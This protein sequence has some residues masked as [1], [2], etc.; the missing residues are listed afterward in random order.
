LAKNLELKVKISSFDDIKA[1][2]GKIRIAHETTLNQKDIYYKWN[3]GLLKLRAE[4][5][6]CHLIKY[7]R[8]ERK[9]KRF[10]N[11]Q[12]IQL[13][14]EDPENY[15]SEILSIEA[16][17]EKKRKLFIYKNTRIHLDEVKNLGKFLELE[18]VVVSADQD[19][20]SEFNE[21]IELLDLD[22]NDELR[23][24]YRDLVIGKS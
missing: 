24:S 10:S 18:T 14:G 15:L 7:R 6:E 4:N 3:N 22:L 23:C 16:V 21:V 9:E 17:V 20:A 11:Y 2:L 19:V 12:I 5:G 13:S 1:R 8:D